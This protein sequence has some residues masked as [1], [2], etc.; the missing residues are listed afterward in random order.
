MT[1]RQ[2]GPD[3]LAAFRAIRLEALRTDPA[4]F[5]SAY[6]DWAALPEAE[7]QRRLTV[8]AVFASFDSGA[9]VGLIGLMR[10]TN[11]RLSHRGTVVMVY[12][13]PDSRG[14]G[15]GAALVA[16]VLAEA[17]RLGLWQIE[18]YAAE[19]NTAALT[20]YRQMGFETVGRLPAGYIH[21][22]REIDEVIMLHRLGVDTPAPR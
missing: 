17:R 1:V 7:W 15:R 4:G 12:V 11:P 5:A 21:E 13:R 2:L 19:E 10:E 3:D 16:A 8:H 14:Q 20:L 22:G 6:Q 9:P 18:L